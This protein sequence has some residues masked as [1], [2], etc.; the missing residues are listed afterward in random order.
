MRPRPPGL[1]LGRADNDQAEAGASVP[2]VEVGCVAS[3][4]SRG[5]RGA[6]EREGCIYPSP[7]R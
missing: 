2:V 7:S 1:G 3:Q 4:R 5:G 6:L